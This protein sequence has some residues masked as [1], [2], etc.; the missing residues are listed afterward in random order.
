MH[1]L[2]ISTSQRMCTE[3]PIVVS[4]IY[5]LYAKSCSSAWFVQVKRDTRSLLQKDVCFS[6]ESISIVIKCL[7]TKIDFSVLVIKVF[8]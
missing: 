8:L 7:V 3:L 1:M 2:D 5:L 4:R 6:N